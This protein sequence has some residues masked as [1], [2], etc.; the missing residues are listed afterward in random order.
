M[1]SFFVKK[2]ELIQKIVRLLFS[3]LGIEQ[4]DEQI[5]IFYVLVL[6]FLLLI[7][8]QAEE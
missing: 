6:T 3:N 8:Q 1:C 4:A 7:A 2:A 5:F